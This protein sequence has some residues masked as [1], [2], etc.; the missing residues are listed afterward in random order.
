MVGAETLLGAIALR[1]GG[2]TL[3]EAPVV[4]IDFGSKF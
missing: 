4:Q 2:V 1:L 3:S